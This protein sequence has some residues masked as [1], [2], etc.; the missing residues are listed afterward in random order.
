[1]S[2]CDLKFDGSAFSVSNT[3]SSCI[4]QECDKVS[5]EQLYNLHVLAFSEAPDPEGCFQNAFLNNLTS[6][7]AC[8]YLTE[9]VSKHGDISFYVSGEAKQPTKFYTVPDCKSECTFG[10]QLHEVGIYARSVLNDDNKRHLL[11]YG[12]APPA[13][14]FQYLIGFVILVLI[15]VIFAI[16]FWVVPCILR[17]RTKNPKSELSEK[18]SANVQSDRYFESLKSRK[19]PE[20]VLDNLTSSTATIAK[21]KTEGQSK[22]VTTSAKEGEELPLMTADGTME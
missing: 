11:I 1:M 19:V 12:C 17:R 4:K 10:C 6:G 5:A 18:P 21:T 2:Q 7:R 8:R 3:C 15:A 13:P 9:F 22:R 20:S 14:W 16:V